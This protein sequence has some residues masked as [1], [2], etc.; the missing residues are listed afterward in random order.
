MTMQ[1]NPYLSFPGNA[2]E[3]MEFYADVLGGTVQVMTFK[4]AG[5][6]EDGVMHAALETPSGF[7]LYASDQLPG[8]GPDLV[9]GNNIQ[10]SISGDDA[11]AMEGYWMRLTEAG[12]VV[13]PLEKQMWGDVYGLLTDRFGISWH[14]NIAGDA[15]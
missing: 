15:V 10:I 1:L 11:S 9:P 7:H 12:E 14:I 6:E 8:M 3:A 13:M 4:D 2:G 5:M